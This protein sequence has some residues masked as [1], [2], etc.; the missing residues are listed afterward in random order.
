MVSLIQAC[1]RPIRE[2]AFT[3]PAIRN[4]ATKEM[5]ESDEGKCWIKSLNGILGSDDVTLMPRPAERLIKTLLRVALVSLIVFNSYLSISFGVMTGVVFSLPATL[6]VAGSWLAYAGITTLIA[7]IAAESFA[8]I[9]IGFAALAAG[10]VTLEC[11]DTLA[12][13]LLEGLIDLIAEKYTRMTREYI[14]S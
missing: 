12:F 1:P 5:R 11:H 14:L 2:L 13:G 8:A 10:W 7:G 4:N 3:Y 9:A 6:I